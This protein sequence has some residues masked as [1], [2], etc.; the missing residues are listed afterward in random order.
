[1][2]R[3]FQFT[4]LAGFLMSLTACEDW[5]LEPSPGL[6]R[7]EDFYSVGK[8]A[9][10]NTNAAYVPLMWEFQ[11]TYF[12]EWFIGDVVSDDAL[13][14]GQSIGDM[15]D[16]YDMENFKT[17]SN[18]G[19]LLDFYRAQWQGIARCNLPL[20]E[21]AKM[22]P[23]S[24][25]TERVQQ[26]LLGE[27]H[28]L[29]ALYYFRLVRVFGGVPKVTEPIVSSANWQQTRA[30]VQDIYSLI[31][32]DLEA[33]N[34]GLWKKSEY[35]ADDLGRATKG[36]AQAMLLKAHLYTKNYTEAKRWGDS[37]MTSN[38]YQLVSNYADNFTLAGENGPE[39]V[40]EIQ[41]MEDPTSD[42]GEGYGF[43]RGTFTVIL[44]RSRSSK[45]GGGWGFNKPTK[46]LYN[47]YEAG[48][49]RRDATIFNPSDADIETPEQEIYL[50]SRYLN[51][52]YA[53]MNDDKSYYTLSH[54]TRGPINTKVIRYAD[55]LLMYAEAACELNQLTAAKNAL[56]QVRSRA[57]GTAAILPAFPYGTYADNQADLRRAIRHE[58]RV[59]LAMEG[60]R[61]FDLTRWGI[62]KETMDAYKSGESAEAQQHMAAFI[63]GTHEL[64]PIP[65]KEIDLNPMQQNP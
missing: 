23:D 37:I 62:A 32:S 15:A 7:L 59:E 51:R 64:F 56:E 5:L 29:R 43:T 48:D 45:L 17:N 39:S 55:V 30:S 18:N 47:S 60:H 16:V 41:F 63:K 44:T 20:Q 49:P 42:Y 35:S 14:G 40:F 36:A 22:T 1:M 58:R 4:I 54:P 65:S 13:K 12:P 26:R 8:T 38:E 28:F 61:W 9:I 31:I 6:T 27:L 50:G 11:S 53:M 19:F 33:A 10:Q 52:K 25:M 46:N 2:K 57:R 34:R 21:I 3:A 24:V